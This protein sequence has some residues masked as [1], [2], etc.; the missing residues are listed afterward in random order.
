MTSEFENPMQSPAPQGEGFTVPAVDTRDIG[1][2][3]MTGVNTQAASVEQGAELAAKEQRKAQAKQWL[4]AHTDLTE[5]V[6]AAFA[7]EVSVLVQRELNELAKED[8]IPDEVFG[9]TRIRNNALEEAPELDFEL[10]Q[11]SGGSWSLQAKLNAMHN[12][13]KEVPAEGLATF[14]GPNDSGY[15]YRALRLVNVIDDHAPALLTDDL[16]ALVDPAQHVWRSSSAHAAILLRNSRKSN[17]DDI[18]VD[19]IATS[20]PISGRGEYEPAD[21]GAM[22]PF[23]EMTDDELALYCSPDAINSIHEKGYA[24]FGDLNLPARETLLTRRLFETVGKSNNKELKALADKRNRGLEG[25]PVLQEGDLVHATSSPEVLGSMLSNGLRCG[26][27]ILG[28]DRTTINYPFTVSF[29]E[30]SPKVA[31]PESLAGRMELLRNKGYG[32]INVVLHRDDAATSYT[33]GQTIGVVNQRQVF[34]GLP[35]TEAKSIVIRD[36]IA[37]DQLVADVIQKVVDNGMFIPVYKG[38]TG[39]S[40]LTSEQF[41]QLAGRIS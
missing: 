38:S 19:K 12:K 20:L 23:S 24:T 4:G 37:T 34:G 33:E 9:L 18:H 26:E 13:F 5:P 21:E 27:T 39:E 25:E 40:L 7:S 28:N 17:V 6:P 8:I 29:L 11:L 32:A 16:R 1:G 41:D 22:K 10:L 36:E 14:L 3:I 30:V 2:V 31:A 35:S 15:E